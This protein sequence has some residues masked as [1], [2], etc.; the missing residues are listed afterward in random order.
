MLVRRGG[1][2]SW[3]PLSLGIIASPMQAWIKKLRTRKGGPGLPQAAPS[4]RPEA[5]RQILERAL[6]PKVDRLCCER[7]PHNG[8]LSLAF[9][10]GRS[11]ALLSRRRLYLFKRWGL[12]N[13]LSAKLGG[14]QSRAEPPNT[15][16][17]TNGFSQ[18]KANRF[19]ITDDPHD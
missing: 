13:F 8:R 12:R 19:F 11:A 1:R 4:K 15:M 14:T 3:R 17:A 7:L 10:E 2:L 6:R 16:N 18:K 9:Y 5:I